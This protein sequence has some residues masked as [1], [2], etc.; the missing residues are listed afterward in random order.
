MREHRRAARR[1]HR[2]FRAAL[3]FFLPKF[4]PMLKNVYILQNMSPIHNRSDPDR[5]PSESERSNDIGE[6]S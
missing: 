3:S 6:F 2:I 4:A 1:V 5:K